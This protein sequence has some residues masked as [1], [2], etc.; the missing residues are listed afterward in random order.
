VSVT[1][2]PLAAIIAA[3]HL[4]FYVYDRLKTLFS[5]AENLKDSNL[6]SFLE[7]F[8]EEQTKSIKDLSDLI[9]KLRRVEACLGYYLIDREL[10]DSYAKHTQ[11]A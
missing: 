3:R 6:Q 10:A 4:E 8:L 7:P 9:T 5:S 11:K 2:L 1:H